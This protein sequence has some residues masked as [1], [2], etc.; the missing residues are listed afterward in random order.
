M[1]AEPSSRRRRLAAAAAW[2]AER[3]QRLDLRHEADAR[4]LQRLDGERARDVRGL[5]DPAG[6]DEPQRADGAHELRPVDEREPLLRL[7]ADR[8]EAGARERV[9]PGEKL[10]LV[11]CRPLAHEGKREMGERREIPRGA[12]RT[13]ARHDGQHSLVQ[14]VEQELDGLDPR[15]RE[16][17]RER[18]RAKD[19]RGAH[20]L[21][22]IRLPHAARVAAQ[23]AELELLG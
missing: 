2:P 3:A 12:D 16:A 22:R 4:A 14:A 17:L 10:A 15:A 9:R 13:A 5:G 6:A 20:D 18:V 7:Q 11:A 8:L 21:V 23:E 1:I 19:H